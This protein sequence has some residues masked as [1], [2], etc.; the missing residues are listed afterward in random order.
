MFLFCLSGGDA[1]AVPSGEGVTDA[2]TFP[3]VLGKAR[4]CNVELAGD[5]SAG[6]GIETLL[7]T[8]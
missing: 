6:T 1:D 2:A 8:D 5:T 4:S 3:S 7:V